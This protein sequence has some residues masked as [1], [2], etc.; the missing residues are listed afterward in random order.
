ML[1]SRGFH[2]EHVSLWSCSE[3]TLF[4]ARFSIRAVSRARS[5]ATTSL[6]S[7]SHRDHRTPERNNHFRDPPNRNLECLARRT[8]T[9][10]T[11]NQKRTVKSNA[12][13]KKKNTEVLIA[14]KRLHR[15]KMLKRITGVRKCEPRMTQNTTTKNTHTRTGH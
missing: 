14:R 11:Q 4:L 1:V 10:E 2:T 8:R 15:I 7:N 3:V 12:S 9:T 6:I 13:T 5:T